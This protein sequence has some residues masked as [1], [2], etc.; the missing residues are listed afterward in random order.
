MAGALWAIGAA[1]AFSLGHVALTKGVRG[2]G[3]ALGT[4]IMLVAGALV[5]AVA[6]LAADGVHPVAAS[7][8]AGLAFFVAAG[9]VHFV[10]G[11]GFMNASVRLIG[12]SR[13]AAITGV[14]PLFAAVLAVIFLNE[15]VNVYLGVGTVAIV[16][17]TY[18]IATS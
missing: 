4:A 11:W 17:G 8:A 7:T 10:G 3:I 6:G 16:A 12:P 9:I 13:M 15:T 2:T 18:F 1:L 14:T 5:G